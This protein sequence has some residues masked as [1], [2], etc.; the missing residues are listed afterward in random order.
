ML[1]PVNGSPPP[2]WVVEE[3]ATEELGTVEAVLATVL[4]VVVAP[5]VVV[6]PPVVVVVPPVVVVVVP[7]VVLVVDCEV[8][9]DPPV[10]VVSLTVLV[11]EPPLVVVVDP[12][13]VVA[14]SEGLAEA[15][16]ETLRP[17]STSAARPTSQTALRL[18]TFLSCMSKIVH[19]ARGRGMQRIGGQT[20]A[21][22][23]GHLLIGA[24]GQRQRLAKRSP[25]RP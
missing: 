8:V 22:G 24:A 17:A 7:P 1:A 16:G 5:E 9:V 25:S 13:C 19:L 2:A 20:T 18:L 12:W 14:R 10:V 15:N 3:P 21:T 4:V 11:V 23:R 6:V